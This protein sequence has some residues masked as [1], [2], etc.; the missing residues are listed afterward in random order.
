MFPKDPSQSRTKVLTLKF[1]VYYFK[2][3]AERAPIG[4][5]VSHLP[6]SAVR[7]A[8]RSVVGENGID[9]QQERA[10]E[11]E[12]FVVEEILQHGKK[13]TSPCLRDFY[14]VFTLFQPTKSPNQRVSLTGHPA[15]DECAVVEW[16]R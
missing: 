16:P 1:C 8:V 10:P 3:L 11:E 9:P 5:D 14:P 6:R 4:F 13:V 2:S 15:G 7:S 12:Q